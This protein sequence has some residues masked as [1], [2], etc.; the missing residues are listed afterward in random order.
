MR[1]SKLLAQQLCRSSTFAPQ[2]LAHPLT[3]ELTTSLSKL[4]LS[5][6]TLLAR[7]NKPATCLPS[8]ILARLPRNTPK[9]RI[10]I[11]CRPAINRCFSQS[12]IKC[13]PS[14]AP[15]KSNGTQSKDEDDPDTELG[16]EPEQERSFGKSEKASQAAQVN[17][18]A[19]LS[20]EGRPHGQKAGLQ[21][22]WRLIKIARPE[23]KVLGV[24]FLFLLISSGIS[25]SIPF[26]IGKIMD[27]ATQPDTGTDQ[28]FGLDLTTFYIALGGVLAIGAAANYGRIIILRI[29]GERIVTRLRSQLFRRTFVQNAEFFDANRTGDLI[30]RLS[31]DTIIVGKSITQNLSDGLRSLVSGGAGLG[32]MAYVS[33]KLTSILAL[34]FPPVAIGA[35]FYGRVIR[36]LSRRI[37]KNLGSLTKIAE[38]RLGNVRTSQA[39]AGEI[40][41]VARYNKQVRKIFDLGKKEAWISATFFSTVC[42]FMTAMQDQG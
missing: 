16:L 27:I 39:F 13:E 15:I 22:V 41:E 33:L 37:Q 1:S 25:M 4:P 30:S 14:S 10:P 19:R 21:E 35:F 3:R 12:V 11:S 40:L 9:Q 31:S 28:L 42:L 7:T 24:A 20:K 17:L 23:A 29:V 34:M 6:Q 36:N 32:L 5:S 2:R 26:S 8:F 38:E 18:S